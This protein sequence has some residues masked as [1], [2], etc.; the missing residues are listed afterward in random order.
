MLQDLAIFFQ[1][2]TQEG[3]PLL[4]GYSGGVDSSCLF[5]LLRKLGLNIHVIHINH[6]WRKS[7]FKEALLLKEQIQTLRIPFYLET[8]TTINPH[9]EGNL[10]E[11]YRLERVKIFKKIYERIGAQ[12]LL[13]AHQKEDQAETVFKRIFEGASL[14]KL[15][16]LKECVFMEE[17]RVLRPL[18][19]FSKKQLY[20]LAKQ[21]GLFF[22]EDETNCDPKY[23]RARQRV[24]IFPAIEKSFGKNSV[25]NLYRLGK[26]CH[27]YEEYMEKKIKKYEEK[28]IQGPLGIY[29]NLEPFYP[30]EKLEMEFVIRKICQQHQESI[31]YEALEMLLS[32]IDQRASNKRVTL[33]TLEIIVDRDHLFFVKN[34]SDWSCEKEISVDELPH[35]FEVDGIL[36]KIEENTSEDKRSSWKD[37]WQGS[38]DFIASAEP[39]VFKPVDL[40]YCVKRRSLKKLYS[41]DRVPAFLRRRVPNVFQKET[42][43]CNPLIKLD[44]KQEKDKKKFRLS[45]IPIKKSPK[46]RGF[47]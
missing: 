46:E 22:V 45:I 41:E 24:S 12:A 7:A 44:C 47:S 15:I 40:A 2:Y 32:K 23:L 16:G 43:K 8:I 9:Q 36:W 35:S 14:S 6:G 34:C 3:A 30:V 39:F 31:S 5:H 25:D 17:M 19:S 11:K 33:T 21:E 20:E 18:L 10:E 42:L 37:F 13:L 29:L 26:S 38:V 1:R 28:I 4:L 27:R